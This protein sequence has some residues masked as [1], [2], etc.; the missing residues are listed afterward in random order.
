MK[1]DKT[2]IKVNL[3]ILTVIIVA[4]LFIFGIYKIDMGEKARKNQRL[5]NQK[6]VI[7]ELIE[8]GASK[9]VLNKAIDELLEIKASR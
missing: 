6:Q 4:G 8:K 3:I 7:Y 5:N 1:F 9:E 2:E